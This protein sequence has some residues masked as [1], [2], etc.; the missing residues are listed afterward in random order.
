MGILTKIKDYPPHKKKFF[1]EANSGRYLMHIEEP[2]SVFTLLQYTVLCIV[3]S[4]KC[5]SQSI[6]CLV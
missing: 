1:D 6:L 3:S 4:L 2:D 5:V